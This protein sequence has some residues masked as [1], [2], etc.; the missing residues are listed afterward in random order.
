MVLS[1]MVAFNVPV[2]A[3]TSVR[4]PSENAISWTVFPWMSVVSVP[5]PLTATKIPARFSDP[6]L[7]TPA[8]PITLFVI[9]AWTVSLATALT[10]STLTPLYAE[11]TID[12]LS[13][14]STFVTLFGVAPWF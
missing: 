14:M 7:A 5:E 6:E 3:M 2:P 9:L 8:L 12:E 4:I 13:W 10:M 11:P 1:L